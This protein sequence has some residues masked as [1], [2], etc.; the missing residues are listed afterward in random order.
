MGKLS[1]GTV[2]IAFIVASTG[3]GFGLY[4]A[5]FLASSR[6]S[7]AQQALSR[8]FDAAAMGLVAG[9]SDRRAE[10]MGLLGVHEDDEASR[11]GLRRFIRLS[12]LLW[13]GEDENPA[14][15]LSVAYEAWRRAIA[16]T[17]VAAKERDAAAIE[18]AAA[19]R[20]AGRLLDR[21]GARVRISFDLTFLFLSFLLSLSAAAGVSMLA[22]LR[23][24]RLKERLAHETYLRSLRAEEETR[25]AVAMELHDDLAQDV[26]AAKMLCERAAA[27]CET[28]LAQRA[29][30]ILGETNKKIRRLSSELRPPELDAFGLGAA[31][32]AI[33]DEA[34]RRFDFPLRYE[35][36]H[37][38][39]RF[40]EELELG[41]YR[42]MR[43]AASNAAKY[44]T[45]GGGVLRCELGDEGGHP[46]LSV[47]LRDEGWPDSPS[48]SDAVPA[49]RSD[50][51]RGAG[52]GL[53]AMRER[54]KAINAEL[55]IELRQ[56]GSTV[57]LRLRP[58]GRR[59]VE[60]T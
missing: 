27:A 37:E 45:K 36:P 56:D 35:G 1:R 59:P 34:G 11:D 31:L 42:I 39:R 16:V 14:T 51:L 13:Y 30:G 21:A 52:L 9:L 47:S 24:S 46:M 32:K 20:E 38:L 41:V 53:N 28:S 40:D 6:A 58:E 23:E 4:A 29:A 44:A 60:R 49:P 15:R 18:L 22:R 54:A 8:D 26:A 10:L 50:T 55:S 48:G 12:P 17:G 5:V 7:A 25:K 3:L 19:Y 57:A 43:E 2:R 33:C